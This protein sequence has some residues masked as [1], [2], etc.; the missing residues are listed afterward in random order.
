MNQSVAL[1]G[2][3]AVSYSGEVLTV[4]G[5]VIPLTFNNGNAS[6]DCYDFY[7]YFYPQFYPS[8]SYIQVPNKIEQAFKILGKLLESKRITKELTVKEF[9]KTVNDI[10]EVI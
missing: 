6:G 5:N 10:A 9:M 3:E 7:H 1:N 8:Y 4:G 2:S